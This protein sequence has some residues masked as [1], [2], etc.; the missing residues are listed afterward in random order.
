MKLLLL[1][2]AALLAG[3]IIYPRYAEHTETVCAAFEHRLA[4]TAMAQAGPA[5]PRGLADFL[6]GALTSSQGRLAAAYIGEQYR[7]LPPLAGCT[8]G[9]WRLRFDPDV[10]PLL[11]KV[12]S[13]GK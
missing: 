10:L 13:S 9:Y 1:A 8:I 4:A 3:A 5:P 11:R 2:V 7:D 12:L 6:N